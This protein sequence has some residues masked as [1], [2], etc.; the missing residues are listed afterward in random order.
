[1]ERVP[2]VL[3]V[4][5]LAAALAAL[6]CAQP[7]VVRVEPTPVTV[8]APNVTVQAPPC[9]C[10]CSSTFKARV[11]EIG[12]GCWVQDDVLVCPLVHRNLEIEPAYP[13]EDPRCEK[14]PDGSLRCQVRER[15]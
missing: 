2:N 1:M 12:A 10:D 8:A 15:D 4:V 11:P 3:A 6:G 13:G 9:Q 5:A 7:Q 14:L